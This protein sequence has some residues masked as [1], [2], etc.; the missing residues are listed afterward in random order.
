MV[1]PVSMTVASAWSERSTLTNLIFF[2]AFIILFAIAIL[3][4]LTPHV[5]VNT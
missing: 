3:K 5:S 4:L 1:V 2:S